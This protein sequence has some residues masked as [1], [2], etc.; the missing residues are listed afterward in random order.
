MSNRV[1][2]HMDPET[3]LVHS[4]LVEW[5]S[6]CRDTHRAWSSGTVLSKLIEFGPMGAGQSGKPNETIPDRLAHVDAAVSRL[7]AIDKASIKE[8][9][10]RGE[11][12]LEAVAR[13]LRMR[14]RELQ[15]VL[16]R[17]RWRIGGYMSALQYG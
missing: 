17:A 9:Y 15:N 12:P 3:R 2:N 6:V 16:R 11:E 1:C 10:T 14:T 5:G 8:Y 7:G 13:R 4:L